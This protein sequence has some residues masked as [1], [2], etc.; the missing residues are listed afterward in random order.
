MRV[1]VDIQAAVAQRAGVGRYV[2][3][4]VERLARHA[5]GDTL[6]LFYFDFRGRGEAPD[7]PGAQ[8]RTIGWMPGRLAQQAWKRFGFPPFDWFAGRADLF[9][10]TNFIRPPLGR[11]RSVTTVYDVSF[12][13]HPEAAEERNLQFLKAGI[14]QTVER[15]DAI[16]TISNHVAAEIVDLLGAP[17]SNVVTAHP[18]L[19]EGLKRPS[20]DVV[21]AMRARHGLDRPYL[22]FVGTI[23]PRKNLA[24]LIDVFDRLQGFDGD[25]VLAGM[26]G[27]KYE[28]ILARMKASPRARRIRHLDYP[29]DG[30]LPALYAGAELF[31]ICSLYEGFG[32]PP[33]E[34]MACGT[35]V[36]SSTGGSLP[37]VLGDAA[38]I[39]P[40]F[41]ADEWAGR[42]TR[43][44]GDRGRR[45]DLVTRG[46]AQAARYTWDATAARVWQLYREFA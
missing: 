3:C 11:G 20:A 5:A 14:R 10:F 35:A 38:E 16:L 44:L 12:L 29:P 39:V 24:F 32:F 22:L 26:K 6:S 9:H 43:L 45:A 8:L 25:L 18:G 33:L 27:W 41:D 42:I 1:C 23:E 15:S 28:P 4:L 40:G 17:A 2:R 7:A 36:V 31:V 34:A 30:D 21:A 19:P 46:T 37:E 13:R